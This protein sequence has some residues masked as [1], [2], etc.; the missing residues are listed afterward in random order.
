MPLTGFLLRTKTEAN[1]PTWNADKIFIKICHC[2]LIIFN[3]T[4][5]WLSHHWLRVLVFFRM[6]EHNGGECIP[7]VMSTS[8]K[9]LRE[10]GEDV[11]D[12]L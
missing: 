11:Y 1:N 9:F 5:A 4:P 3:N 2:T 8:V 6:K 7:V 10:Y 12:N